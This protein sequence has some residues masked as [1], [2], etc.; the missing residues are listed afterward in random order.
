MLLVN[1]DLPFDDAWLNRDTKVWGQRLQ[2]P[3]IERLDTVT[4]LGNDLP[5]REAREDGIRCDNAAIAL[6][7]RALA[8]STNRCTTTSGIASGDGD[9]SC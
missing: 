3:R 4:S 8:A 1:D 6:A 9:A 2:L 5:A 7:F